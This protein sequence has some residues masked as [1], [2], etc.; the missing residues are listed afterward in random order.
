MQSLQDDMDNLLQ[1]EQ[2]WQMEF[3]GSKCQLLRITNKRKPFARDYDIHGHKLEEVESAKYLGVTIQKNLSWN[4][5]IDQI[6]KKAN[7]TRA[8][9][10]RNLNHCLRET[11]STCYLT[12]VRPLLE[13]ACMVW[14]PHT[15]QNTQKLEAV[16]RRPARFVMNNYQQTSSVT[17]MLQTLQWPTLAE[18]RARI[19]ATMMYRIVNGLVAIPPT[20]QHTSTTTARGHTARFIVPYA[21]TQ[22]YR[23]SF[24]P[25]TIQ[26]WNGL[27]Q[28]FVESTSLETF[29]QGVLSCHIP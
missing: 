3:H 27:P 12:L 14:D 24:F 20:E 13:F 19:K 8:F 17:S 1:W 25:D 7:S 15:A 22:L 18:R 11:K 5:H 6:T 28:P 9:I 16:Q 29:K 2:E 26:I 4:I 21:R 23:N 10:Q